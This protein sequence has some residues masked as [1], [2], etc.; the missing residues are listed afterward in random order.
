MSELGREPDPG[1]VSTFAPNLLE[2]IGATFGNGVERAKAQPLRLGR[3]QLEDLIRT[4]PAAI[5]EQRRE[6]ITVESPDD[7]WLDSTKSVV[8]AM[9]IHELATNAVKYG[10]L[11]NGR[12]C[13]TVA[14]EQLTQPDRVKLIWRESGGPKVSPPKQ[15]GFGSHLIDRAFGGNP[16][17]R[18]S[19]SIP[20]SAF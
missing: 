2:W 9:V 19:Y 10:A 14:W 15:K 13:V 5:H 18:N 17:A 3:A 1:G 8:V 4:L 11:S 20:K 16:V 12:G 7:L 6:R